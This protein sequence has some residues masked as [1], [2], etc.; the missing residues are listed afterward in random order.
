MRGKKKCASLRQLLSSGSGQVLWTYKW[1]NRT[2]P[3]STSLSL[4]GKIA[5]VNTES[6]SEYL[7]S[8]TKRDKWAEGFHDELNCHVFDPERGCLRQVV[9]CPW[10]TVWWK[11][12]TTPYRIGCCRGQKRTRLPPYTRT[13]VSSMLLVH[14][15]RSLE[16]ATS[17]RH[18]ERKDTKS[19][20]ESPGTNTRNGQVQMERPCTLWNEMEKLWRNK[21]RG[22]KQG[23]WFFCC[24]FFQWKRG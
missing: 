15:Q 19:C 3:P 2:L 6:L 22:K 20:R 14:N 7:H 23:C 5:S 1:R 10:L 24:C 18:M 16:E 12:A 9:L 8:K 21:N 4:M 13:E 11:Q 17:P